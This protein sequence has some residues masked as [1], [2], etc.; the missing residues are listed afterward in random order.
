MLDEITR[1]LE[2]GGLAI[3][4]TPNPDNLLVGAR[5]FYRDPTHRHPIPSETLR[6]LVESRGLSQA[7]VLPLNPSGPKVEEEGELS[8]RFNQLLYGPQDY[9]VVAWKV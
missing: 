8:K 9:A 4:E 3:L 6:F 1:A 5:N 2:T 7:Q